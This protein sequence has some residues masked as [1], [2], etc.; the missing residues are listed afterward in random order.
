M[1]VLPRQH[2]LRSVQVQVYSLVFHSSHCWSCVLINC[3][4]PVAAADQQAH[5]LNSQAVSAVYQQLDS[6]PSAAAALPIASGGSDQAERSCPPGV[7]RDASSKASCRYVIDVCKSLR[8]I[9]TSAHTI[10]MTSRLLSL[11]SAQSHV[12]SA[13]CLLN[14]TSAQS[15]VYSASLHHTV[16][17]NILATSQ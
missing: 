17:P 5:L 10:C 13:S 6:A 11:T 4:T 12:C 8:I 16:N 9:S 1:P 3:F 14:L 15:H 7:L 2:S